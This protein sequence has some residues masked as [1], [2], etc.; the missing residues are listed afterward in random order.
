MTLTERQEMIIVTIGVIA[1]I[2]AIGIL[3]YPQIKADS[4]N[5]EKYFD[6]CSKYNR[7]C[8]LMTDIHF[9]AVAEC[10]YFNE[11]TTTNETCWV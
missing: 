11:H 7:S 6:N 9:K 10:I 3:S 1:G 4:E 2:I 5:T 8:E